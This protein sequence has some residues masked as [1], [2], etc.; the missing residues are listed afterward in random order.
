MQAL[1]GD[2]DNAFIKRWGG[3][4][5]FD[6]FTV[7]A[8]SALGTDNG[9]RVFYG[10]NIEAIKETVDMTEVIT[11]VYPVGYNGRRYS[12]GSVDSPLIS[13][14]PTVKTASREYRNIMLA[15]DAPE[16]ASDDPANVICQN[17]AA[18]NTALAAAVNAEYAAGLDKP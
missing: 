1:Q 16:S 5:A 9:V 10:K 4:L 3:E 14:Y 12:S 13:A 7:R 18:L 6:N 8:M 11:R 17:Q 2:D 15:S